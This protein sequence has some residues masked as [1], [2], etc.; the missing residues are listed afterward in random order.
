MFR[1]VLVALLA[2]LALAGPAAAAPSLA[3]PNPFLAH[4]GL[5]AGSTSF[6]LVASSQLAEYQQPGDIVP[7]GV[8]LPTEVLVDEDLTGLALAEVSLHEWNHQVSRK[9]WKNID[10]V[11]TP[12]YCERDWIRI[13]EE[14][15]V[16]AVTSDLLP[17]YWRWLTGKKLRSRVQCSAFQFPVDYREE[18]QIWRAASARATQSSI[19]SRAAREWRAN[20]LVTPAEDR[21][22]LLQSLPENSART[23]VG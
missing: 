1:R 19:R 22:A 13:Y 2:S 16:Q 17:N 4:Y 9:A 3:E 7:S 12:G 21:P 23:K 11:R 10:C 20:V 6:S 18:V 14:G 5:E 15:P 8:A